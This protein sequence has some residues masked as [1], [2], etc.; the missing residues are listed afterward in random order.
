MDTS[1]ATTY[2]AVTLTLASSTMSFLDK[3]V[4]RVAQKI[5]GRSRDFLIF[6]NLERVKLPK[7]MTLEL[8]E[9]CRE[10]KR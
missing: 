6:S 7:P 10:Y 9:V 3:L 5:K 8:D 2:V 1:S 4:D